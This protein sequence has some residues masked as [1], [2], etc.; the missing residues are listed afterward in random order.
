MLEDVI[1]VARV[2]LQVAAELSEQ[3]LDAVA[4]VVLD[5]R[6][7]DRVAIDH[8]REEVPFVQPGGTPRLYVGRSVRP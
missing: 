1:D 6:E 5:L 8:R 3:R 4:A 7:Q 2:G